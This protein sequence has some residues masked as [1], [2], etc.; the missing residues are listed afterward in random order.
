MKR[1]VAMSRNLNGSGMG[2]FVT[3]SRKAANAQVWDNSNKYAYSQYEANVKKAADN[4][5]ADVEG[6]A[7]L[8][9]ARSEFDV[10][11]RGKFMSKSFSG[12]INGG[13]PAITMSSGVG[14]VSLRRN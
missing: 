1:V 14:N 10:R 2:M 7:S 8:G 11:T 13:G 9:N 3:A 4:V 12:R 6:R 5:G